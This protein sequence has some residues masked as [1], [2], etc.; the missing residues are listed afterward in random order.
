MEFESVS[1]PPELAAQVYASLADATTPERVREIFAGAVGYE[2][3]TVT[4]APGYEI[5]A[6]LE[7]IKAAVEALGKAEA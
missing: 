4:P 1:I 2:E 7:G 6:L 3:P 5:A